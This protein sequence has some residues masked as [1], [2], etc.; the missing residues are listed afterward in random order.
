[1]K[2]HTKTSNTK[3]IYCILTFLLLAAW[4]VRAMLPPFMAVFS[5]EPTLSVLELKS[6]GIELLLDFDS[7]IDEYTLTIDDL[8]AIA[9]SAVPTDA[10]ALVEV[11]LN[12]ERF[13]NH[14]L[15]TP[16]EGENLLAVEVSVGS[17]TKAY[18][19]HLTTPVIPVIENFFTWDNTSTYFVLTDRF[20][21]GDPSN[22]ESYYRH[23]ELGGGVATFHGGDIK[24]LTQKLDYLD[25]LGINAIWITAPYE[26]IHG[27]VSGKDD[28]F[29]HYA[30]HGY[31]TQDWTY[32][33]KNMGTIEEFR[34]FV[35][36]AHQ[37]GIR[38][39]MD[40]V[41]NHSG[42]NTIE[43]MLTYDF[44]KTTVTEHGWKGNNSDWG[45]NHDV[46]DYESDKWGNWWSGWARAFDGK[47]GF[48]VPGGSD[49]T[50]SLAGLPDIMTEKTNSVAIPAFLKK[51][52]QMESGNTPWMLPS[53]ANLRG[54]NLGAPA[55]YII[56]W[57][58]AWVREFGID[59]F[60]CDTA[61]HLELNRWKQL[62][63][64]AVAA[65]NEWRADKT[66]SAGSPAKEWADAFWMT[67]ECF[68]HKLALNSTYYTEGGFDSM[69]NFSFNGN[70]GG[71]G[72]TPSVGDWSTYAN[73]I[74][75]NSN[76]YNVLSYVSSHDTGLHR[77]SDMK[78][79]GTMLLLMPG[80]IQLF[81]GDETGRKKAYE[82][83]GDVDMM[84]RGDMN[85]EAVD[86]DVNAHWKRVGKF[87][88]RNPAVGAGI[89]KELG[90]NAYG[91][92]YT[93]GS[94][95]N[96]VAIKLNTSA[97]TSCTLN[98]DGI[99]ADG[100]TVQDGY[101]TANTAKVS[102][103]KVT[104]I[105]S[106]TVVL[107]ERAT[108]GGVTPPP[109]TAPV[110]TANPGSSSFDDNVT[111]SLSV[112]PS[113]AIY[114]TTDGSIPSVA[115]SV[116]TSPLTFS[117]TTTLRTYAE[118]NGKSGVKEFMYT[119]GNTPPIPPVS[120][121]SLETTYYA[122][123]PGGKVGAN[124]TINIVVNNGVSSSALSN[125][126]ANELIAQSAARDIC[127]VF[128]GGH[129][130]PLYDT[131]GLYAAW[132]DTYLYVGWQ[133]VNVINE[134]VG[135]AAK[136]Y[137]ADI[138]Q[139]L[140]FDLDPE[141]S[142]EGVLEG[143]KGETIWDDGC[144]QKYNTF[145]NGMDAAILFSSKPTN[146]TPGIF[147]PKEDGTFSYKPDYCLAL[148]KNS[149]G[150]ADGLLPSITR[151]YGIK[152]YAFD[153]ILLAGESDFTDLM[154]G[155][156]KASDTFYE[157][158]IPLAKLGITK[159][160]IESS[161]IGIMH[162]STQ[163]QSAIGSIPYDP[164][165]YDHAS[166]PY[167]KDNSSSMEKEDMDIFTYNMARVG[168]L[169]AGGGSIPVPTIPVVAS[170][171]PNNSV[172]DAS[173]LS[174]T[175]T[176]TGNQVTVAKY[177]TDGSE[178]DDA[179][180]IS[181]TNGQAIQVN[182]SAIAEGA[183]LTL[184][185][186]AKNAN[187]TTTQTY[188][189]KHQKIIPPETDN[190]TVYFK[191]GAGWTTPSLYA[192]N[193]E[194]DSA[195]KVLGEWPGKQ[196]GA[197]STDGWYTLTL[198][199]KA[200]SATRVIFY[201]SAT[202][203]HPADGQPGIELSFAGK[204][205]WY[206][207]ATKNWSVSE[208]AEPETPL[209]SENFNSLTLYQVMVSSFQ[210]G[211]S[212]GYGQGYGPSHH[213]GDLRGVIN[214]LDYIKG[215]GVNALWMTPIFDSTGGNGGGLL[216]ST[217]YFCTDYFNVD[218]KFGTKEDFKELVRKAHEK[219]LYVILDGVFGHH[220][221]NAKASPSGKYPSGSA[222]PVAYP[223]S[224]DFYKEVATYWINEYEVDGWRLD[225]CYQ[226]NQNGHNYWKEIREAVEAT[227][228]S[229]KSQG[230][231]WGVLG[232][233]VG[234]D[235]DGNASVIQGRTYGGDGLRSA[236]DFPGR[237]ALV[238]TIAKAESDAGGNDVSSLAYVYKT[239]SEKGY[240]HS[241]GVYP[242][243]FITNHD[244]WRF[245]NLIRGKYGYGKENDAYWRRHKTAIAALAA[246]SGP[247][248]LYYGDEIG[249]MADC[250]NGSGGC[251]AN[252]AGDNCARTNGQISGLNAQQQDLHDWVAKVMKIRKE[253]PAC[254]RGNNALKRQSEGILANLKHDS[255]TGD[256]IL[257]VLSN[258]TD[259]SLVTVDCGGSLEDLITGEV[260]SG[261]IIPVEGLSAR[262]FKVK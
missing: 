202:N 187:G 11:V 239:P 118:K 71:S 222:N 125:W 62:K 82:N 96:A 58:S 59:G 141:Q 61:K 133:L 101:N 162:I 28:K 78:N 14:S 245:G 49:L 167:S 232:Y 183:Y 114:Y 148:E 175:L 158:K 104:L 36:E 60:R 168:K 29:P 211:T 51:K 154:I 208:P 7:A 65:L 252:V 13:S 171:L 6:N 41:L 76:S 124:K 3:K 200:T 112:T 68:G 161:G 88:R 40:I 198:P 22:D 257:F 10:G 102:G 21:N 164:T 149:Y 244:V 157:M 74:N 169:S 122:T 248:T 115:S 2:K 4:G 233:M 181:F 163:G 32:M 204:S 246:Y 247:V 119:K 129:E 179:N 160:Y 130:Y 44:G 80:G 1:M 53:A 188:K 121:K 197:A 155:H 220:G 152:E 213:N 199:E 251:G 109:A 190:Y 98:V 128:R 178:P 147:L 209:I 234:E 254:W 84:T 39:V 182:T 52:W 137:Q 219:G 87:R 127:Q 196:M 50:L 116:Y 189:Y 165:V 8:A 9:V 166:E 31:Y 100:T 227:C 235:W 25:D 186:Y 69:I 240:S 83:C 30:F 90:D 91:R 18:T 142:C 19:I 5:G 205:G 138:R 63:N 224:L 242:N 134:G 236:F 140:V 226:V 210:D 56:K 217:G 212:C 15:V 27:W 184:R 159:S 221:G 103:G 72:S 207:L 57:L 180:G 176:V 206:D 47:F 86:G 151:V 16:S 89:Q 218:P 215:L 120:G 73:T 99:F 195:D 238:N 228:D 17:Q 64:A 42:Y 45:S 37:R 255:A 67:G 241:K 95:S 54:D 216:N 223:G 48:G 146:G 174:L 81:Y 156:E 214:A 12:G 259:N 70:S 38:I 35:D 132:D 185:L 262:F 26:Q 173:P 97:G 106:G 153:P 144:G 237:Y 93:N 253:H 113:T 229:R 33:D 55:D 24:G 260:I 79:V 230:K 110:V 108:G 66:K 170:S 243:L 126:T 231:K 43:D 139:M 177:T 192:Y 34:T 225:Q 172:F 143:E 194:G 136:P 107:L 131:Y 105:A 23:K 201:S 20:Y 111:V 46:S 258:R 77:P 191:P 135:D 117:E 123:N 85:W 92:T 203:R 150:Y 193:G 256:K 249:D 261:S 250:W 94:Y 75:T 145:A